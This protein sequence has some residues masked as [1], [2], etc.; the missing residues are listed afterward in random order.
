MRIPLLA[1]PSDLDY[2]R[3]QESFLVPLIK[4]HFGRRKN[5][6]LDVE[7]FRDILQGESLSIEL[8][9]ERIWNRLQEE[10]LLDD[11][12]LPSFLDA[13][14]EDL[15]RKLG[16][17]GFIL[18][19]TE[20]TLLTR[21]G[22]SETEMYVVLEG[23]FEILSGRRRIAL[24]HKGDLI[25]EIAFF[26]EG[27]KRSASIRTVGPAKVLVVRRRF[28]EELFREDPD[29]AFALLFQLGRVMCER[30][31]SREEMLRLRESV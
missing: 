2:A 22:F 18:D 12:E 19:L 29:S 17:K 26:R 28:L 8:E 15:V 6:G 20:D 5:K 7:R 13:L 11:R 3:N 16:E 23:S 1:I 31:L 30:L 24:A 9:P 14:P 21:E 10:I 25:G 4:R 27:G